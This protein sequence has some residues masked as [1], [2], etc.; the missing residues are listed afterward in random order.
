M[1]AQK[2]PRDRRA[3]HHDGC[4]DALASERVDV[5]RSIPHNDEV[6]VIG[7]GHALR[8]QAQR[9]RA[10]ALDLGLGADGLADEGVALQ[11]AL[12]QPLQVRL[13]Q[14]CAA[15]CRHHVQGVPV[16]SCTG[17]DCPL[18]FP[19]AVCRHVMKTC[20]IEDVQGGVLALTETAPQSVGMS[21]RLL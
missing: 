21:W 18:A 3:T 16:E 19:C 9:G 15:A 2:V 11:G 20:Q 6:V 8:A 1:F 5:A 10:H 13:L 14:A 12:M 17:E 4:V 7:L